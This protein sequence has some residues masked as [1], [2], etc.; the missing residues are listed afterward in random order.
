M[1]IQ[2]PIAPA[3]VVAVAPVPPLPCP[4]NCP[5][6]PPPPP[7]DLKFCGYF[8]SPITGAKRAILLHGDD[9]FLASIGDVVMRRYRILNISSQAVQVEDIPNSN[10]QNL[11]LL[12]N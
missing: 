5:P 2:K 12:M 9:Q 7:I 8:E 4:P 1:A 10:K 11:P 3:R 6:P